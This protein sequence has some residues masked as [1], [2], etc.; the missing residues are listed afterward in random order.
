MTRDLAVEQRWRGRIEEC[1]QSGQSIQAWCM[2]NGLK[3]TTY[4][5]WVRKFK[6]LEPQNAGDNTFAEVVLLPGNND[7]TKATKNI[8][9]ARVSLY[10]SFGDYSI[11]ILDGFNPHTLAELVKVLQNL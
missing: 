1:R 6:I 9:A 5:Y 2:Q 7:S 4:Y 10:V 3:N 11:G 8:T